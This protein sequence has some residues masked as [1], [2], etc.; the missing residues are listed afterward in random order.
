MGNII[1]D[2]D[3][4]YD[5]IHRG[6]KDATRHNKR[7]DDAL[8]K[9]LKDVIGRQDIIT[10]D[11]NKKVKI[12]LKY[13]DQYRFIYSRDKIDEIGRDEF[14]D[15]EEGEVLQKPES[16]DGGKP[17]TAGEEEGEELYEAE[18]TIEE[19]T[20]ILFKELNLPDLDEQKKNEI[21]SEVVEWND[22][23]KNSGIRSLIDKKKT[24]LANIL[25]KSKLKKQK[26][27]IIN[28]D[29]RFRTYNITQEKYSNA[30]IFLMMDKSG[31]MWEEKIYT[32]KVLYFWIVQFL[33]RR[34]DNVVIKFIAHDAV[35]RELEEKEFFT[36]SDSGGTKV[37]SAYALCRDMIKYNYPS[38][39]WNI[40]CFHASDGDSWSDEKEC[41]EIVNEITQLGAK[42]FAYSE[43]QLDQYSKP[44]ILLS[45]FKNI[46]ETNKQVLVSEIKNKD[47]ILSTIRK[48]LRHSNRQ[49]HG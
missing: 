18:Y 47:G 49:S 5:L 37:S 3:F 44:S 9:Q 23:N 1:I 35:A 26:V 11:K 15:L 14:D 2:Q 46:I 10:S 22:I 45:L 20:D 42:L 40:Y 43:I 38:S 48:F 21:V 27:P 30:V 19:L 32:V 25:R 28:D 34:Y 12:R 4:P 39:Q 29:M 24:L 7:V 16:G 33:R 8:R 13:L 17:T 31:S 41:I 36:I 6:A